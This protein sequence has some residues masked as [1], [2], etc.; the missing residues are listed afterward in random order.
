MSA[1]KEILEKR[2]IEVAVFNLTTE[3]CLRDPNKTN[4]GVLLPVYLL[5]LACLLSCTIN[6]YMNRLKHQICNLFFPK[7]AEERARFLHRDI[8][9]GRARRKMELGMYF[10]LFLTISLCAI[11][12]I[13]LTL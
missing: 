10:K 6:V 5:L 12:T 9:G 8:L 2:D 11:I 4:Q 7:R 3:P 13:L 1:G